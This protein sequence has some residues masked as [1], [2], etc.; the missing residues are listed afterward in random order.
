MKTNKS[1]I[2]FSISLLF[3]LSVFLPFVYSQST[4]LKDLMV[5]PELF[6]QKEVRVS[7]EAIGEILQSDGGFWVNL[8][9]S[10]Y[11]L[12]IFSQN[13]S[14]F[15]DISHWGSYAETGD[16]IEVQGRFYKNCFQH[17][18]TDIHMESLNVAKPGH[19]NSRVVSSRKVK[20]ARLALIICFLVALMYFLKE[21][22]WNKSSKN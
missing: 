8:L 18:T 7:G 13:K 14:D 17:Q 10:G 9:S 12:G 22:I 6:D 15:E 11:N 2:I 20:T 1:T 5:D 19:K 21:K 4:S 3:C 16:Q